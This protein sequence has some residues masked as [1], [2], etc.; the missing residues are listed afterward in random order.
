MKNCLMIKK[1]ILVLFLLLAFVQT[2]ANVNNR[3]DDPIVL[4]SQLDNTPRGSGVPSYYFNFKGSID[5]QAADDFLVTSPSGWSIEEVRVI[6]GSINERG[7]DDTVNVAFFSDNGGLPSVTPITGC[8]YSG[9]QGYS[10][11]SNGEFVAE[12]PE[13]C[14]LAGGNKYWV[15]IQRIDSTPVLIA[16]TNTVNNSPSVWRQRNSDG[17]A[18]FNWGN[19]AL[20]CN[21]GGGAPSFDLLFSLIGRGE[22]VAAPSP[23]TVPMLNWFG[24]L[25]MVLMLTLITRRSLLNK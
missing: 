5:Q 9:L 18:C 1:M 13:V 2:Q 8:S 16:N 12:L 7:S 19:A 15:S 14:F 23:V 24:L 25:L 17:A 21:V 11:G 3:A 22:I 6:S 10:I 4:Y 20:E